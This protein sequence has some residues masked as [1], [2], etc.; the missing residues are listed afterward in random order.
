[1]KELSGGNQQKLILARWADMA[2]SVTMFDQPTHGVDARGRA[3]IHSEIDALA[4]AGRAVLVYSTDPEE[5]LRLCHRVLV[6]S[7]GRV[8]AEASAMSLDVD[9]LEHLTRVRSSH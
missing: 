2:G 7:E 1:M 5:T 9:H 3:A 6:M 8:V 4:A